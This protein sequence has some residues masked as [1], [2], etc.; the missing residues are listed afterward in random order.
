MAQVHGCIGPDLG[1]PEA[2]LGPEAGLGFPAWNLAPP[3]GSQGCL[4]VQRKSNAEEE[5]EGVGL[6]DTAGLR[7]TTRLLLQLFTNVPRGTWKETFLGT[8]IQATAPINSP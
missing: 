4:G 2:V 6:G 7:D 5:D 8:N 1:G 3:G